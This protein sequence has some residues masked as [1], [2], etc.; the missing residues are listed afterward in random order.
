MSLYFYIAIFLLSF[1]FLVRA[2]SDLVRSLTRLARFLQISEYILA[3]VLMSFATTI[4][5]LFVGISSAIEEVPRLSLGNIIGANFINITLVI[6]IVAFLNK[7]I[8]IESKI[9][10]KNFW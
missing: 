5:E 8:K 10:Q 2:G 4:P 6:G 3:F 1:C 9:S 7:G